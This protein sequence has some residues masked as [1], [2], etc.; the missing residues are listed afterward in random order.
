[1]IELIEHWDGVKLFRV[2]IKP[3]VE[4]PEIWEQFYAQMMGWA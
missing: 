4:S 1:M 2:V 3:F